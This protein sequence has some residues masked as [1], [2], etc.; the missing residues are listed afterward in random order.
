[1]SNLSVFEILFFIF[2][3]IFGSFA[4]VLIWRLP[5]GESIVLPASH[6]PKCY[7]KL[8]WKENIPLLGYIF[9]RG[10]CRFCQTKIPLRYFVVEL[11]MALLFLGAFIVVGWRWTLIEYLLLIFGLVSITFIDL[12]HL[13]IP[14]KLSYP[15]I[16]IGLLGSVLNP[17]RTFWDG[18][19][20]L[21]L[22]GGFFYTIAW[23]YSVLRKRE[24]LGGGDIK[25]L[26][27]IGAVLGWR[28]IP[29]VILG[30][31]LIG[32]FVGI[33]WGLRKGQGMQAEIPFGPFISLATILYMLGQNSLLGELYQ[34]YL[35]LFG[36]E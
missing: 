3:A 18:F 7:H 29:F 36:F 25:L 22:G 26:A 1:M 19:W 10:H 9:L 24:G 20:G 2:G 23:L 8:S 33:I 14:N 11:L 16:V 35:G 34:S 6:C 31:S 13:I 17:E 28:A 27:W 12:D 15:G 32:T 4:N 30:S 5:R 21:L